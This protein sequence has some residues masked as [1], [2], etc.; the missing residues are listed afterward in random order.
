MQKSDK[1]LLKALGWVFLIWGF[2]TILVDVA[3]LMMGS[4]PSES[5]WVTTI[6]G[7][8]DMIAVSVIMGCIEIIAGVSAIRWCDKPKKARTLIYIGATITFLFILEAFFFYT[9]TGSPY[10]VRL[11]LGVICGCLYLYGAW[12]EN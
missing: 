5:L 8:L 12:K 7:S 1:T 9:Q 6:A 3:F 4:M 11:I 2:G 10:W